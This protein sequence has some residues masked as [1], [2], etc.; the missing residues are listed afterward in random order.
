MCWESH[1]QILHNVRFLTVNMEVCKYHYCELKICNNFTIKARINHLCL[2][3]SMLVQSKFNNYRNKF[4]KH[5]VLVL[6]VS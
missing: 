5:D 1:A 4:F 6:C 2:S 3:R